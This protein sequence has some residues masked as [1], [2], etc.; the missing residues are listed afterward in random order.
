MKKEIGIKH[1]SNEDFFLLLEIA[2]EAL[3][4]LHKRKV[5]SIHTF[6]HG[7]VTIHDA[8]VFVY[9]LYTNRNSLVK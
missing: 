8:L 4:Q 5:D 9:K 1:I 6:S 2:E 3:F 7:E